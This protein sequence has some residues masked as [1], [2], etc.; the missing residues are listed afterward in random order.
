MKVRISS[1]A[2][3]G[4]LPLRH[5]LVEERDGERR[6]FLEPLSLSLS[7]LRGERGRFTGHL[8]NN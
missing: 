2:G 1:F 7:P 6:H 5:R 8:A 3:T 4:L